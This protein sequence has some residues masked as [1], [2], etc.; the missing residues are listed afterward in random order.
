MPRLLP[1]EYLYSG[2]MDDYFNDYTITLA[3]TSQQEIAPQQQIQQH[4]LA[5]DISTNA[6]PNSIPSSSTSPAVNINDNAQKEQPTAFKLQSEHQ[7]HTIS[8]CDEEELVI[9]QNT[10][11][12]QISNMSSDEIGDFEGF[13]DYT[14]ANSSGLINDASQEDLNMPSNYLKR[15][16]QLDSNEYYEDSEGV[17]EAIEVEDDDEDEDEEIAICDDGKI[18]YKPKEEITP[19]KSHMYQYEPHTPNKRKKH[20]IDTRLNGK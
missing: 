16:S 11:E 9:K 13:D 14:T 19:K 7:I 8:S 4:N 1:A 3:A 2:A 20:E 15:L 6:L 5:T 10:I 18:I 12:E 17:V